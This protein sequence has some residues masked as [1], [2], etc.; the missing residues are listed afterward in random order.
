MNYEAHDQHSFANAAP[1]A[2]PAGRFSRRNLTW[3]VGGLAA[4]AALW[5]ASHHGTAP[6]LDDASTQ[7]PTITVIIP[8][9]TTV[10]GTIS[11]TGSLA[12]RHE[13]PVGSVGDGGEVVRVLVNAGDWVRRGQLLVSVDRQVQAQ[14]YANQNANIAVVAADARLAQ[15]N[16]DRAQ[17]LVG[18]GFISAADID[19]LTATRDAANARV[20]VA[21]A[22]LG[23]TAARI[24]RLDIVAPDDGLVLE[25]DVEPG[26]VVGPSSGVL[27]RIAQKGE[28]ELRARLSENDLTKLSVGQAAA[29]TP[30]GSDH[31]VTGRI[32]QLSP[33]VD[34]TSRQGMARITLP[35]TPDI[36]PGG[37]ATVDIQ[38]GTVVAPL[39]PES[40]LQSDAH[41]SYVYVVGEANKVERRS[42]RIGMVTGNGVTIAA[43]LSG[44]E[45]VVL[46]A[47]AFLSTGETVN[48]QVS[49]PIAGGSGQ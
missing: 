18:R 46:R 34:L 28:M 10:A 39:L 31:P 36:R 47:G 3:G 41:G 15:A 16:L 23:E 33:A 35:Y 21:R 2:A 7:A 42:V 1:D 44:H 49:G 17:K 12:A 13:M 20:G 9:T 45:R 5:F 11:A 48:P 32:W 27:F 19:R 40:V 4:L 8:G 43:G 37:F 26:Q 38:S 22:Q 14:Q 24:R 6:A 29:V 25:R 30:V